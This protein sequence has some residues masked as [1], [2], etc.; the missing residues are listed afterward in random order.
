MTKDIINVAIIDNVYL[1]VTCS[2]KGQMYEL[3]EF[4]SCYVPDYR[5][6]PK[7]KARLWNGKISFYNIYDRTL[8]VGLLKYLKLFL[9]KYHYKIRLNFKMSDFKNDI[10]PDELLPFYDALFDKDGIYPRDY[11]QQ[12][13]FTALKNKRGIL[14][15]ATGSGKSL[16]IYSILRYVMEDVDGHVLI[17][18]PSINLV[19]QLFQDF[20]DYGWYDNYDDVTLLYGKSKNYDPD[21]KVTIS[22]WQ[23]IYKKREKFFSQF[24][25][26][27]VDEVHSAKSLSIQNILKKSVNA[28]YRIGLTGT[29]PTEIVD[30]FNIFGFLGPVI[31]KL[32]SKTLIDNGYLSD[33]KIVNLHLEYS[34]DETSLVKSCNF[35]EEI[36]FII[37]HPLRNKMFD[38]IFQNSHVK[39]TDNI[40]ILAQRIAHIDSIVE[41]LKDKYPNK[42]VLRT[43]GT[44]D[45]QER[46]D[47]RKYI[48]T[49][50][51]VIFVATYGTLSTGANIPKLHHVVL[52]S[53]YKAKIK[54][55]QSIGRGLRK[56]DSKNCIVI[57]DVVDDLRYKTR[58]NTYKL[59][60]T[61]SHFL[62]RLEYY[63]EQEFSFINKKYKLI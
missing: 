15:A 30:R 12:A 21:K 60:Y 25:A 18:V 40:L 43:D 10:T 16:V 8:P 32:R 22:T 56:H 5:Y 33:I 38:Y 20:K 48:E 9:K 37:N 13:I 14:E 3:K 29:L 47:I 57:W 44:T 49:H 2:N 50:D 24:D 52:A 26:V 39:D 34:T 23:S 55:L 4:F 27:L 7:Y 11:Q 61:Y 59:N 62:K 36:D 54:V 46:E 1:E 19:T 53:S 17:V 41:Y 42:V 45:P 28:E 51:G 58:N 6:N 35:S 31:Y 63:K